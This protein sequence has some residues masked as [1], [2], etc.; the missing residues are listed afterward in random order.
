MC[1]KPSVLQMH[2]PKKSFKL[3]KLDY[4]KV[5]IILNKLGKLQIHL[6]HSSA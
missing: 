5:L 6:S 4:R 2:H 1:E 3:I